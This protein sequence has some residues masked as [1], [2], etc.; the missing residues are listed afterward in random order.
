GHGHETHGYTTTLAEH[1][2]GKNTK[3]LTVFEEE[4]HQPHGHKTPTSSEPHG[5]KSH[6]QEHE[7]IKGIRLVFGCVSF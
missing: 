1:K 5:E 7:N 2:D 6:E 4:A 3:P